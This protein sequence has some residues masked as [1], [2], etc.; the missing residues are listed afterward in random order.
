[1]KNNN[2]NELGQV[3]DTID[4][5]LGAMEIPMPAEF[6]VKQLK[7]ALKDLSDKV[8]NIYIDETGEDPW[9]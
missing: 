5:L 9:T 6:H 7:L 8:R 2:D 1:M 4:N 3:K